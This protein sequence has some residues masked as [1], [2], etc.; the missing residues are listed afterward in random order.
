[1]ENI[2]LTNEQLALI[3]AEKVTPEMPVSGGKRDST[4]IH[5]ADVYLKWLNENSKNK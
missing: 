1:M 3:I 2:T 5:S 4:V